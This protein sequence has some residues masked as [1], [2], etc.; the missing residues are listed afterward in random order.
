M[1]KPMKKL[2]TIALLFIS[3]FAFG[4]HAPPN[5]TALK[6]LNQNSMYLDTVS[7]LRW[8]FNGVTRGW[9]RVDTLNY[10]YVT[11]N[12]SGTGI[13]SLHRFDLAFID[14]AS[15]TALAVGYKDGRLYTMPAGGGGNNL[16]N[17]DLTQSDP[18]R[19][20]TVGIN[21][22][23]FVGLSVT[24]TSALT[25]TPHGI[26]ASVSTSGNVV[27]QVSV[28]SAQAGFTTNQGSSSAFISTNPNG[29]YASADLNFQSAISGFKRVSVG[30]IADGI[31][32]VLVQD[33]PD[34]VGLNGSALFAVSGDPTQYVQ[35]GNLPSTGNTI[36]TGD[37]SLTGDRTVSLA[38]HSIDFDDTNIDV[39]ANNGNFDVTSSK[40]RADLSLSMQSHTG[41]GAFIDLNAG[42]GS[43][44]P[45]ANLFI[46]NASSKFK[47][48]FVD[49]LGGYFN[50]QIDSTSIHYSHEIVTKYLTDTMTYDK[51]PNVGYVKRLIGSGVS[52]ITALTGDGAATGPGSAA[53]TLAIVNSNVG[54]FG[55]A[56]HVAGLT[57]NAKGLAT[58]ASSIAIT[59]P[60]TATNSVAFTN[61]TGNISQWTNDSG[62]I[63]G[64]QTISF[65][66]TGDVTGSTTGTTSL[67]PVLAIGSGKVTNTM[68]AGS[69]AF[70][71]LIG[72]D[73]TGVGTLSAGSIPYSLLTGT[74]SALPPNGTAAGELAGSYPNPTLLNSAVIGKVLT[75]YTSGAGTVAPT[76]NI[77][78]AIQKINGN[79]ALKAPIAS[80]SFT[81]TITAA[82]LTGYIKGA[83]GVLSGVSSIPYSDITGAPSA[84]T[85]GRGIL[86]PST[87]I[88]LDTTQNYNWLKVQ[89]IT[90]NSLAV[91]STDGFILQN[92][93]ASTSGVPNQYSPRQ[94]FSTHVWNTTATA[95]DN[96]FD[97]INELRP[98]SGATPSAK[99]WWSK[100]LSTGGTGAYS[101]LMYLDDGGNLVI[102]G[103][104]GSQGL[105]SGAGNVTGT[106]VVATSYFLGPGIGVNPNNTVFNIGQSRTFSVAGTAIAVNMGTASNSSGVYKDFDVSQTL[107]QTSTAGYTI[108]GGTITETGTG[109]G[110]KNIMDWVVGST[111]VFTVDHNGLINSNSLTASQL[112]AT[113]ALKNLVSVNGPITQATAD[114]TAQ[115]AS[116]NV[117]TFTVGAS[118]ATFNISGYINITAV[119]VDVIEMQ[120]TYTDENSTSQTA[121]F[122]TQGATSA[123]LSAIGN[124]VYPP[125]TIRAKNGTVI[126]VKTTLTTGTGSIT[127]DAGG[128]ITQL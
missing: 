74:P 45:Q 80:P 5:L 58:A 118:T 78:Q 64:N 54:S 40:D 122:F 110:A 124:S 13:D 94:R 125:M 109:S 114:L 41:S 49:S 7:G 61:K 31:K 9:Y 55:D 119:T 29:T 35:F 65:S 91:T 99:L 43:S 104:I 56:T 4:Q 39:F 92:T 22:L 127:F 17:S 25:I 16:G 90:K 93:T 8:G 73:I 63:T 115:S 15:A 51:V 102:T 59:F 23:Q 120:V 10:I 14:T 30:D 72:T 68:L 82:A 27:N 26:S 6:Q 96:Q 19:T 106:G 33:D 47:G 108:L 21:T 97:F 50:N 98:T 111:H 95:A 123:L 112:V 11:K 81:G 36:Y 37:G 113:D 107:N 116:G 79:D 85:P 1:D 86:I 46:S 28:T 44:I 126:T 62:Y 77:L 57:V 89:T 53:F 42:N 121:N 103:A 84:F 83:S 128:R 100:R 70:S 75:G 66:P 87:A 105:S 117:T 88:I 32:G 34:N 38:S 69:I 24:D 71:K 76:D 52:G 60:V 101:D 12:F 18:T 2:I 20:F 48:F 67:A 3:A